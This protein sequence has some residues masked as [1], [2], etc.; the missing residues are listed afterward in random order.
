MLIH[1]LGANVHANVNASCIYERNIYVK[2][3]TEKN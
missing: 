3:R 2:F 1:Y